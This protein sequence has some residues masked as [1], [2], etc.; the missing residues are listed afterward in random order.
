MQSTLKDTL[1]YEILNDIMDGCY[2]ANSIISEA[3]IMQRYG[4][5]KSTAREA[6]IGLCRNSVLESLPRM[7]YRIMPLS[8]SDVVQIVELRAALELLALRKAYSAMTPEYLC[9]LETQEQAGIQEVERAGKDYRYS[10]HWCRNMT[11]HL[12]LCAKCE[13]VYMMR[14]LEELICHC[15]RYVPLYYSSSWQNEREGASGLYHFEIINALKARDL[16]SALNLLE[17][18]ILQVRDELIAHI[19]DFSTTERSVAQ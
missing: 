18:D 6:L 5:S 3:Q 17:Q 19:V 2:S 4:S 8:V 14:M 7:G 16:Q 12:N 10:Q 15:S 11:F 1:Y 9:M 13:N